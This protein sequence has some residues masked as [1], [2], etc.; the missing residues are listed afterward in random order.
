M[1]QASED[2]ELLTIKAAAD[3]LGVSEQTLRRWDRAGKLRPARHPI[4]GYRLYRRDV[5]NDL[6]QRIYDRADLKR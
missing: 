5:I 1:N 6:R 3:V 2:A 4:N